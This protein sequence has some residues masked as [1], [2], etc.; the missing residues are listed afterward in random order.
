MRSVSLNRTLSLLAAVALL[1][2]ACSGAA[3]AGPTSSPRTSPEEE[4][5]GV[6]G[7]TRGTSPVATAVPDA[8]PRPGGPG[9]PGLLAPHEW[10]LRTWRGNR[11]D[12]SAELQILQIEPNFVGSGLPH[13]GPWA[14][15]AGH[16]HVLVRTGAH[17]AR[18]GGRTVR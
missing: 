9:G 3:D 8:T 7:E 11:E 5:A 15:C 4:G 12:R 2:A 13:V 18:R 1:A 17:R 6:T 16:P 10:L 14:V